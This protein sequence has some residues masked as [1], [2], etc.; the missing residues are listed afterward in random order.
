VTEGISEFTSR[1]I[2]T[3]EGKEHELDV[4]VYATGFLFFNNTVMAGYG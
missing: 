1:G 2:K 4:V 3:V